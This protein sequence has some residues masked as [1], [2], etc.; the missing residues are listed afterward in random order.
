MV[1]E[2]GAKKSSQRDSSVGYSKVQKISA[3]YLSNCV[4]LEL[5]QQ[6]FQKTGLRKTVTQTVDNLKVP[7]KTLQNV[8]IVSNILTF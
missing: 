2:Y 4:G 6:R 1:S 3:N 7:K 5:N 8:L